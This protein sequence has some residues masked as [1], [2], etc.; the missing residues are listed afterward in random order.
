[1]D[2]FGLREMFVAVAGLDN[3]HAFGK[4][5]LGQRLVSTLG[6]DRDDILLVGDTVHDY[7]V[8]QYPFNNQWAS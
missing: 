8:A 6:L 4:V 1:M 5:D 2:H 3:H 7:E